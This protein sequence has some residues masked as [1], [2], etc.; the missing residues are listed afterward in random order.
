[1]LIRVPCGAKSLQDGGR[2]R[3]PQRIFFKATSK[4]ELSWEPSL[5]QSRDGRGRRRE[6]RGR[7]E[8]GEG[9]VPIHMMR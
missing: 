8:E 5:S 3:E 6:G 2:K 7:E 9:E 1:M 4:T